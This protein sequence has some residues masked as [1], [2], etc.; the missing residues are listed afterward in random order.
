[1]LVATRRHKLTYPMLHGAAVVL[2]DDESLE[3]SS[4]E[5]ILLEDQDLDV[6][7]DLSDTEV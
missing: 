5:G 2:P 3:Q 6:T 4:F 7:N 1:M